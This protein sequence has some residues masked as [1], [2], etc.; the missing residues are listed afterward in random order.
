MDSGLYQLLLRLRRPVV[1][2]VGRLG[3]VALPAG[4]LVYTG[5]ARRGLAARIARHL[6]REKRLRWHID[7]L[8]TH[9]GI[10]VETVLRYPARNGAAPLA[11]CALSR[12]TAAL[13][14]A[15]VPASGLGASDCRA[16]CAAHLVAFAAPPLLPPPGLRIARVERGPSP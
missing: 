14:G 4:W 9:S 8:T 15:N 5:S 1:L 10:G 7:A 16:G 13:P 6:R 12:A 2:T 3:R 11:E